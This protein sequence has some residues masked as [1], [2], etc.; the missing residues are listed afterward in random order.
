MNAWQVVY[1]LALLGVLKAAVSKSTAEGFTGV[2]ID[3]ILIGL[4]LLVSAVLWWFGFFKG[5]F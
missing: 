1:I 5:M 3:P 4:I 2:E